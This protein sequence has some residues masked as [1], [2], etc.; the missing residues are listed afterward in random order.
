MKRA[1][2]AGHRQVYPNEVSEDR[3]LNVPLMEKR[4]DVARRMVNRAATGNNAPFR[5][6]PSVCR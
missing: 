3:T 5:H 1:V 6:E 2:D 4:V